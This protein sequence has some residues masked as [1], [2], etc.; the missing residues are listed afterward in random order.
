MKNN[1]LIF[2]F[3][4]T[5]TMSFGQ[6]APPEYHSLVKQAYS[7][8]KAKDYINSGLK[9]SAAFQTFGGLGYSNHRYDAACSWALAGNAD[10]EFYNLQRIV[11]KAK[12]TNYK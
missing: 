10:S 5:I 3:C 4:L 2:G 11:D 12:Y 6:T 8:Y 7:L 9:F 1:Y